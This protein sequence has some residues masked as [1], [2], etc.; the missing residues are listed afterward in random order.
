VQTDESYTVSIHR[1][2]FHAGVVG[3]LASRLR[4][5]LNRPVFAFAADGE[6]LKGSGRSI[7]A[8]HLRDALDLV[9]KR[10]PGVIERFGGH[11]MAA[12]AT[13]RASGLPAFREAFE[14]VARERL[15]PADLQLRIETDG[16]LAPADMSHDFA[17]RLRAHVWGQ[18]FPEPRFVARFEVDEQRIVGEKHLRL[19]LTCAGR[20][21][22][23]I[24]F[25]STDALPAAIDAVYRLDLN[26][27]QGTSSLQLVIEHIEGAA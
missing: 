12:G 6:R 24:R 9:D 5:R 20:R 15:S 2:D 23:A 14:A 22:P 27:Y 3:L 18:G 1:D 7:P 26:E 8:L 13:L 4:E 11:A 25:G 16:E 17:T 10:C 19:G 21:F